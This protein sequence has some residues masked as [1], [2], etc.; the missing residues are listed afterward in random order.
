MMPELHCLYCGKNSSRPQVMRLIMRRLPAPTGSLPTPIL[1]Y[2]C[3]SGILCDQRTTK[4]RWDPETFCIYCQKQYAT[5]HTFHRHVLN[6][7]AGSL[8]AWLMMIDD[9]RRAI[10]SALRNPQKGS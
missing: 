8:R 6:R 10:M 9:E 7:H 5:I 1:W 4:R 2:Q 3:R